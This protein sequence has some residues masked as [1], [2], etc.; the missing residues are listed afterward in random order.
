M[1]EP[2]FLQPYFRE[3][4][5]GGKKLKEDFNFDIPS[6]HTGEAWIISGHPNGQSIISYPQE[7]KGQ[8]LGD[9]YKERPDLFGYENK[10][11]F[12]LLVKILD[13]QGDLS[14]QVHPDD[15]YAKIH[16]NDLGKRECWYILSAEPSAKI[17][18]G[19]NAKSKAEFRQMVKEE[20]W[21]DLLREIP[22]KAGEFYDVPHG[23]IHAIGAGVTI[24]ETQ[25]SS[26]T[27]YR[28]YDYDRTDSLGKKRQLHIDQSIEVAMIPHRDPKNK[29]N[30]KQLGQSYLTHF[31]SH[32]YFSVYKLE[33]R[34]QVNIKLDDPY[35][36]VTVIEGQGQ[37]IYQDQ[38]YKIAK[39]AS[40]ILPYKISE[41]S[42][43]GNLNL[44]VS[45][46][47]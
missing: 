38:T 23:T 3:K 9:L 35:T 15:S 6:E 40:F 24:L 29:P 20:N 12:P 45:G 2:I 36:L 42:L 31:I 10:E 34:N 27:T 37:I 41:V 30:I 1:L 5:W 4:I 28:V 16:E 33:V 43:K 46:P 32:N 14:V 26:D 21:N 19:H 47:N 17:I 25:Q 13:A 39:G 8:K 11:D 18:Y 44:I 22:V 7:M